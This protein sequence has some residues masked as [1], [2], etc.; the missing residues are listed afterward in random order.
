MD[1]PENPSFGA[2]SYS[3]RRV[4]SHGNVHIYTEAHPTI[5]DKRNALIGLAGGEVIIHHD[6][7]DLYHPERIATQMRQLTEHPDADIIGC[8]QM[9]FV[10]ETTGDRYH[11]QGRPGYAIGVSMCYPRRT[12]EARKFESKDQGEDNDFWVTRN[13][14]TCEARD[15]IVARKHAGNS[16]V[17]DPA[18]NPK[19]WVPVMA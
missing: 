11:Y 1:D 17:K 8:H 16:S 12:W 7:D 18:S 2:L 15:M 6:D 14:Y 19:M 5:G 10:E 9:T 3:E 4:F 13:V